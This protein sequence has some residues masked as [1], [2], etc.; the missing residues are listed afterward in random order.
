MKKPPTAAALLW[1]ALQP[2]DEAFSAPKLDV[3][4][5]DQLPGAFGSIGVIVASEALIVDEMTIGSDRVGSIIC[6]PRLP[7][8]GVLEN[9]GPAVEFQFRPQNDAGVCPVPNLKIELGGAALR[10]F[11]SFRMRSIS[12]S[13][14]LMATAR[15]TGVT[16]DL[17]L[18]SANLT[19]HRQPRPSVN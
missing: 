16:A 10:H 17:L 14:C 9:I 6:H 13:A 7:A 18:P 19:S 3:V 4:T 11:L 1:L 2:D 12:C 15:L 5:I 8:A